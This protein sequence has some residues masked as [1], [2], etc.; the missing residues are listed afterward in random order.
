VPYEC[1]AVQK[2][3]IHLVAREGA[4]SASPSRPRFV[5]F[6]GE[7]RR[8]LTDKAGGSGAGFSQEGHEERAFYGEGPDRRFS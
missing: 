8:A 2:K 6:I 1:S 7:K 3:P 5:A 4:C